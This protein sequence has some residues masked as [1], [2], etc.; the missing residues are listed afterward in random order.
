MLALFQ[1]LPLTIL[2]ELPEHQLQNIR[3][4]VEPCFTACQAAA[5]FKLNER[6]QSINHVRKVRLLDAMEIPPDHKSE[7]KSFKK[8]AVLLQEEARDAF[9]G[10]EKLWQ[11]IIDGKVD[12]MTNE[13]KH[14]SIVSQIQGAYEMA[15]RRIYPIV[16]YGVVARTDLAKLERAMGGKIA[17][18]DRLLRQTRETAAE[19]GVFLQASHFKGEANQHWWASFWWGLGVAVMAVALAAYPF[20]IDW[21]FPVDVA[22]LSALSGTAERFVFLTGM[23]SRMLVFFVLSFGLFF[24]VR[25]YTAHRHNTVVNRHRQKA[26]ETYRALV[27]GTNIPENADIVLAQAARCIYAPQSTGFMRADK[28]ENQMG[29]AEIIRHSSEGIRAARAVKGE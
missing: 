13:T 22:V 11:A 26:L 28:S 3:W 12:P 20:C 15:F 5:D 6:P 9:G 19:Q 14:E 23:L 24:C 21:L 2:D 1:R 27:D 16:S 29:T 25:N 18:A 17:E 10:G 7:G 8:G 4:V